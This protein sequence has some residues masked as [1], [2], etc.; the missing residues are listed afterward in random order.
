M[1]NTKKNRN[2]IFTV[3]ATVAVFLTVAAFAGC[4]TEEGDLQKGLS[5]A[6]QQDYKTAAKYFT[7]AAEQGNAVAQLSLGSCYLYGAGVKKD[8]KQAVKW[9]RM[10]ADQSYAIAQ[11]V[12]GNCYYNGLGVKKNNAEA[13]KWYRKA[14]EQGN[15]LAIEAL[16]RLGAE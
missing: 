5:A 3:V 8:E 2:I 10:S 7:A 15:D 14:A 9:F 4:R 11:L 1:S 13:V 12:L 16:K 6:R